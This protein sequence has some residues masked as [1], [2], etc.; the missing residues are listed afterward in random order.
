MPSL[1]ILFT[2]TT[3]LPHFVRA[4]TPLLVPAPHSVAVMIFKHLFR[5]TEKTPTHCYAT[6]TI[7]GKNS[8][9]QTVNFWHDTVNNAQ[10]TI[11]I[12]ASGPIQ[13]P[14]TPTFKKHN[15]RKT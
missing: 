9:V 7:L 12:Q 13:W 4:Q 3:V 8:E 6:T 1:Q 15:R 11:R 14:H 2:V 5:H 10:F